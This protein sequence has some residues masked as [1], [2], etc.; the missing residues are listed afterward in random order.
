MELQRD[1]KPKMLIFGP[2][3]HAMLMLDASLVVEFTFEINLVRA[4]YSGFL[5]LSTGQI[6]SKYL[7][8]TVARSTLGQ[9]HHGL[10]LLNREAIVFAEGRIDVTLQLI[11]LLVLLI[12]FGLSCKNKNR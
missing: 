12:Y 7:V 5:T 4:K 11:P 2:A 1:E 3:A 9:R 8:A 6:F 10:V